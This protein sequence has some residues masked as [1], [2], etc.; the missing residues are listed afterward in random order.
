[1]KISAVQ[2]G[3]KAA[4][5]HALHAIACGL[6]WANLKI[7]DLERIKTDGIMLDTIAG[8]AFFRYYQAEQLN[9]VTFM[10]GWLHVR[11][12]DVAR[13]K[14]VPAISQQRLNPFSG[15]YNFPNLDSSGAMHC[16]TELARLAPA[17][18]AEAA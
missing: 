7:A 8:P 11:F 15:K 12:D 16:E 4:D 5:E 13:A 14:N 10:S 6:A 17:A 9:R 18:V 2:R 3:L 1:M